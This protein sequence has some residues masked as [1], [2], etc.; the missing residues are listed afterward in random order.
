MKI[1][2]L[3]DNAYGIGGTI[4]STVN[5][6]RAL[7]GRHEVE[8]VTLRRTVDR[9]ALPFDPRI[10]LTPLLD[11]RPD[12]PSYDGGHPSFQRPSARFT[13]GADHFERGIST[14]LGDERMREYLTSTDADV[15]IATRPKINDYLAAYGSDRYLRVGQEH[16]THAMHSEHNRIHQDAAIARLDAFVTVSYADAA[17]YRSLLAGTGTRVVCVPNAV[18]TPEV[19]PS[20]GEAKLIV[21]A[22]RLVKVKRYD[23]LISAFA[24][25]AREH[26]DWRLRI[27]GRGRQRAALRALINELGLYDQVFLMGP[28]SPIETEWA[29]GSIAAVSSD[30]ESFGMTLVEAMHCGVPVVSTDCPHGP[31][32]IISNG[33]DGLLSP[34][35]ETE[36]S[37]QAFADALLHLVEDPQR[38]RRMGLAALEKARRY[39]PERIAG[40]YEHLFAELL[41]RRPAHRA[42]LTPP[43]PTRSTTVPA[44]RAA[45]APSAAASVAEPAP[46][47]ERGLLR[48]IVAPLGRPLLRAL[49]RLK[50]RSRRERGGSPGMPRPAARVLVAEDGTVVVRLRAAKLPEGQASLLLRPRRQPTSGALR[51][52]IPEDRASGGGRVRLEVSPGRYPMFEGRWDAYVERAADRKRRRV[53]AELVETA[54]LLTMPAQRDPNGDLIAR[55]PYTTADGYLA[56]RSWQ[57]S[58][59]AEVASVAVESRGF[60]LRVLLYTDLGAPANGGGSRNGAESGNGSGATGG[61]GG[62]GTSAADDGAWPVLLAVPRGE[63][64]RGFDLPGTWERP[65]PPAARTTGTNGGAGTSG[66]PGTNGG[67]GAD[68]GPGTSGNGASG[69]APGEPDGRWV[70]RFDLPYDLPAALSDAV[71]DPVWDLWVRPGENAVPLRLSRLLDDLADRKKIDISPVAR[72]ADTGTGARLYFTVGNNLALA[73]RPLPEETTPPAPGTTSRNAATPTS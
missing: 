41:E 38:R 4:R 59:H 39:A 73:L 30:A 9:P 25:V 13:E 44:A 70:L 7:A 20:T 40:E 43:A 2:F 63:K 56:I 52:P 60:V 58:G 11:L 12:S 57:R 48:R 33:R 14:R 69:A 66:G 37:V 61:D 18:P 8:V 23:R 50:D 67:A 36:F 68:A 53:R 31:G 72:L 24:L 65:T 55:I 64:G 45:S 35:G 19:E 6:S 47:R 32:E 16:L 34:L 62:P 3:L 5:L 22:G 27:Y 42:A 54:R 26:P 21:A 15:V 46:G 17:D 10:T 1:A 49:R 71:D 51:L 29:K 28:H